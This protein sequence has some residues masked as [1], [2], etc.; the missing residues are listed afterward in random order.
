M[1]AILQYRNTPHQD[2]R[3]S[4]AQMVFGRTL[5]DHIPCLPH[6]YAA[7]ADWCVAQELRER[8]MAKSRVL[9]SDT[10]ARN[11]GRTQHLPVGT[12]VTIQNQS[13]RNPNKWDKTGVVVETRPHDQVAVK[14]DGSRRLMLRK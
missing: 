10:M 13:G 3:R 14:V 7:N 6:K 2:C 1:K 4:S 8:M 9:D 11:M 12:M 5:R